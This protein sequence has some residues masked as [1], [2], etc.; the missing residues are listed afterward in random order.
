MLK[1]KRTSH[2]LT[3][4]EKSPFL[5]HAEVVYTLFWIS[6]SDMSELPSRATSHFGRRPF[7]TA[8]YGYLISDLEIA[9]PNSEATQRQILVMGKT[10]KPKNKGEPNHTHILQWYTLMRA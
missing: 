10:P 4:H 2:S 8:V 7:F 9:P 3:R 1:A 5:L 6:V